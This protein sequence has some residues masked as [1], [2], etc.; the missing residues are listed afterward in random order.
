MQLGIYSKQS[1]DLSRRKEALLTE[2]MHIEKCTRKVKY[3][4]KEK[5]AEWDYFGH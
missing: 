4:D 2:Q 3:Q 5:A 1:D